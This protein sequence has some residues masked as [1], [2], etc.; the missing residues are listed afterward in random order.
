MSETVIIERAGGV[1]TVV[2]DNPPVNT[3]GDETL[4][5]LTSA[6]ATLGRDPDV[7]AIV[8]AGA[9]ERTF[10]AGADLR[11]L[12]ALL[13]DAEGMRDHVALTN[14]TFTAWAEL[15]QPVIAAVGGHAVGGGLEV[16][17]VC[18]L[19][20]ADPRARLGLPEVGL[21]LIP[22]AGGTQRLPR[23]VGLGL[24]RRLLMTGELLR[25]EA[26]LAAGLVDVVSAEGEALA[27]ARAVAERMAGLPA[28]A[29]QAAKAALLAAGTQR[30]PDGLVAERRLFLE[31][32]ASDDAREGAAA[33]LDKR[34]PR[35]V[36]A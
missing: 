19:I 12:S 5:G 25:A 15:P 30:L 17:L 24:A 13:G 34:S 35:F 3:L 33:F 28:R 10:L 26:A 22:G 16:A 32:A 1:A 20:V 9:G 31:V 14:E 29:V 18:D 23:R 21:G 27:E 6:A 11:E 8:L 4:A 36:H 7:R 2:V